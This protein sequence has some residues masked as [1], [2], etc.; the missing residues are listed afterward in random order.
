MNISIGILAY[1]EADSISKTLESLIEQSLFYESNTNDIVEVIVVANGCTDQ[2]VEVA[3]L[4]LKKLVDNLP[5]QGVSWQ[6]C[7]VADAGIS[8]AWN[9]YVHQFSDSNS[10]YLFL[11]DADI[12]FVEPQT[13]RLMI[14][15]LETTPEMSVSVDL[16]V[17]NLEFKKKK[18]LI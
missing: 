13:L 11:M 9:L 3:N 17:K 6:V 7:E 18:N 10:N 2:T 4:A 5:R 16:P 12:E 8:N 1:N 15:K 14:D